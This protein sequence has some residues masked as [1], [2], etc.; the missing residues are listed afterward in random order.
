MWEIN[1][2]SLFLLFPKEFASLNYFNTTNNITYDDQV[3]YQH[4][5]KYSFAIKLLPCSRKKFARELE[6]INR[7]R[8]I[9]FL[10]D[11]CCLLV[12]HFAWTLREIKYLFV[13]FMWWVTSFTCGEIP[14]V[15]N[16]SL[17]MWWWSQKRDIEKR[18]SSCLKH[19]NGERNVRKNFWRIRCQFY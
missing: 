14:C 8:L 15:V 4:N 1:L 12:F 11:Y 16:K 18:I 17:Q 5:M 2:S 3:V 10:I 7:T 9:P 6:K 19:E 13:V